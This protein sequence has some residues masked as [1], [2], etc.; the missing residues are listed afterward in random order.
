MHTWQLTAQE[1]QYI[2]DWEQ[3]KIAENKKRTEEVSHV[4]QSLKRQALF[5]STRKTV[6]TVS[7]SVC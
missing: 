3:L 2:E 5:N 7:L 4:E 6:A 1:S